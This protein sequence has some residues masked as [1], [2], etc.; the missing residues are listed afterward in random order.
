MARVLVVDDDAMIRDYID[1]ALEQVGHE[2]VQ[3]AH[4]GEA[5]TVLEGLTPDLILLDMRMPTMD[6]W[7]FATR[8]RAKPGRKAPIVVMT[9]AADAAVRA[10]QVM[11]DAFLAKP[12]SLVA[13]CD[14]IASNTA[15]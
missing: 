13:L 9:A 3:A 11:A 12:F 15:S 6:G 2:V 5:L 8:Y 1:M 10:A 4:G 7:E 14:C